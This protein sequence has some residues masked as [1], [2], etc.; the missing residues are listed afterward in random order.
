MGLS[1]NQRYPAFL[2]LGWHVYSSRNKTPPAA[3]GGAEMCLR[4]EGLVGFRSSER[5]WSNISTWAINISLL[6][7]E[8]RPSRKSPV[9]QLGAK[10]FGPFPLNQFFHN[11]YRKVVVTSLHCNS[12]FY[13]VSPIGGISFR[14]IFRILSISLMIH[15]YSSIR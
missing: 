5:R 6:R 15:R 10:L 2:A 4:A 9:D 8:N 14:L 13:T 3:F 7:S 11:F 12:L 1:P